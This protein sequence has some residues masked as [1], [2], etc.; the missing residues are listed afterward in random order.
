MPGYYDDLSDCSSRDDGSES[1]EEGQKDEPRVSGPTQCEAQR[2]VLYVDVDCFYCQCEA[3]D[4][5][6]SDDRPFAIGQ[7]HIIVT[8]NYAARRRGVKKLELREKA[9]SKCPELVIFEGSDLTRYRIHSRAIY[10]AFRR[11]CKQLCPQL[12]VAK[13]CMDEMMADLG[14]VCNRPDTAK[15]VN[16]TVDLNDVYIY[17]ERGQEQTFLTEDQT[18]DSVVVMEDRDH[19]R[20]NHRYDVVTAAQLQHAA[21]L[22]VQIR[23]SILRD[24]GFRVTVGVSSNRLLAKLASGLKKPG[25]V[26]LLYPWRSNRLLEHLPLRKLD[27]AGRRTLQVLHPCLT[28]RFPGRKTPVVWTC[29][30]VYR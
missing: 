14:L 13:G 6:L 5:K 1:E 21:S 29:R 9:Y 10:D 3:I 4:R 26:N 28:R 17:G 16:E 23:A 27:G 25:I 11:A 22:A 2:R 30:C 8:C 7:K 20:R 19:T 12:P 18:G 24:T 15:L